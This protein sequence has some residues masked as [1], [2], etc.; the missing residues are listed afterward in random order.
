[1]VGSGLPDSTEVGNGWRGGVGGDGSTIGSGGGG[2]GVGVFVRS[3]AEALRRLASCSARAAAR[4][5]SF[6]FLSMATKSG[7]LAC[8]GRGERLANHDTW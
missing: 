8:L 5:G 2:G 7:E 3:R 6:L 1:M 4:A